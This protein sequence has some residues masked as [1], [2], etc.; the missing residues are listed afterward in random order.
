LEGSKEGKSEFV[1]ACESVDA[2]LLPVIKS[3]VVVLGIGLDVII[4]SLVMEEG[5]RSKAGEGL[6]TGSVGYRSGK[7]LSSGQ[8]S[9]ELGPERNHAG[10]NTAPDLIQRHQSSCQYETNDHESNYQRPRVP[11]VPDLLAL[12]QQPG[13]TDGNLAETSVCLP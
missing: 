3:A 6:G 8:G 10:Q 5:N 12:S 2:T 11:R 13:E 4:G 1:C 9:R 7:F